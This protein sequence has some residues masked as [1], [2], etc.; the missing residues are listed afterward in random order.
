MYNGRIEGEGKYTEP[1]D[2]SNIYKGNFKDNIKHGY[3]RLQMR[4]TGAVYLGEFLEG[5]F[6]GTGL[7]T[8]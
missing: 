3:G 1:G 7:Y 4:K 2:F 5:K 6:H 8:W